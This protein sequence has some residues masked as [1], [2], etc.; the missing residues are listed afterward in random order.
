MMII[1]M[2]TM[3]VIMIWWWYCSGNC[4]DHDDHDDG[5]IGECQLLPLCSHDDNE[6]G[7]LH[8]GPFLLM[9][10]WSR[11]WQREIMMMMRRNHDDDEEKLW[12]WWGDI[13]MMMGKIMMMMGRNY[14]D[15]EK[16]LWWWWGEIMIMMRR[17][18]F[19]HCH[20]FAPCVDIGFCPN[21]LLSPGHSPA[22]R[23]LICYFYLLMLCCHP[24]DEFSFYCPSRTAEEAILSFGCLVVWLF[25]STNNHTF[26][27]KHHCFNNQKGCIGY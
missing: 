23:R 3:V 27:N 11:L 13:M 12:W 15:D 25:G 8:F 21:D 9:I 4:D 16:K 2:M 20:I 18:H 10:Q 26:H 19:T 14:D 22:K 7:I 6:D 24:T 5:C 1:M 17:W